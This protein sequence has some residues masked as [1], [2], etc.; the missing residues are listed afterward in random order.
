MP[1]PVLHGVGGS[2]ISFFKLISLYLIILNSLNAQK[3][4]YKISFL[5]I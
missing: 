2:A 3:T 5:E 4:F 1:L